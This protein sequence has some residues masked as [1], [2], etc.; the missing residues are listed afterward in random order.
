MVS[1]STISVKLERSLNTNNASLI[2]L[3]VLGY[4]WGFYD[5]F[6]LYNSC[7]IMLFH[8]PS[9][10]QS[11]PRKLMENNRKGRE[12]DHAAYQNGRTPSCTQISVSR[13]QSLTEKINPPSASH[14]RRW[15]ITFSRV[16]TYPGRRLP[17]APGYNNPLYFYYTLRKNKCWYAAR[18]YRINTFIYKTMC[19]CVCW[20]TK[21][22]WRASCKK[23]IIKSLPSP[24]IL[25][26]I[27]MD[28]CNC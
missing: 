11:L 20:S 16:S 23:D 14:P 22:L 13:P 19:V 12:K 26:V 7:I 17:S 2:A 10:V 5:V 8:G 27:L 9:A 3:G 4:P 28:F 25:G 24:M 6:V 18:T 1:F 15:P 21:H